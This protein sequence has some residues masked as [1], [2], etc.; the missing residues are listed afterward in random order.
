[1]NHINLQV[2]PIT[3][4]ESLFA[5]KF[6]LRVFAELDSQ[7]KEIAFF[8]EVHESTTA[9]IPGKP[10]I[11]RSPRTRPPVTV[12][13]LLKS[14]PKKRRGNLRPDSNMGQMAAYCHE[15]LKAGPIARGTLQQGIEQKF[16]FKQGSISPAMSDLLKP[17]SY[18]HLMVAD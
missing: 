2:H 4:Q 11:T 12:D 18:D 9:S 16:G 8:G 6:G 10:T 1:M 14:V 17:T 3:R 7:G 15:Q 5:R 13:R